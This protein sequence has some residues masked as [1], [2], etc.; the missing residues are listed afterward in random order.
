M[1]TGAFLQQRRAVVRYEA[2]QLD[3]TATVLVVDDGTL[4]SCE[5]VIGA[6]TEPEL[7][8]VLLMVG[9]D[10]E[11]GTPVMGLCIEGSPGRM[12]FSAGPEYSAPTW[13]CFVR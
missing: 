3:G 4:L 11:L 12:W 7:A 8:D 2:I 10:L 13:E 5:R 1:P 9:W 6:F